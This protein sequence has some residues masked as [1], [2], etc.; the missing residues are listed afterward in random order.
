VTLDTL[1]EPRSREQKLWEWRK[2]APLRP[3]VFEAPPT[4]DD[5][6][7]HL[8]LE[9]RVAQRLL[10]RF[11][12]QGFVHHDL[13]RACFAQSRDPIPRVIL[14]GRLCLY[15]PGAARLHEE[16]LAVTARWSDPNQGKR[17][18]TPYA[19]EAESK[20][21][22]LLEAALSQPGTGEPAATVHEL[23]LAGAPRDVQELLPSLEQR[24]ALLAGEVQRALQQRGE[25]EAKEMRAILEEQRKRLAATATKYDDPQLTLAFNDDEKRQLDANRRHWSKRLTALAVELE[26]EPA[27]IREVYAVRATRLEPVGL[28]YLWPVTG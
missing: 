1:R 2:E 28:V 19:R 18:L 16:L 5:T 6:V 7:V 10:G 3:V 20:T 24:G 9:H 13:A 8:H 27:W 11:R 21:L 26:R 4:L 14:L 25:R 22:D 12:A 23:L 17:P 15:G